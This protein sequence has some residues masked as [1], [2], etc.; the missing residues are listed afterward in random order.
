[1]MLHPLI[2]VIKS[3]DNVAK[4]TQWQRGDVFRVEG[5]SSEGEM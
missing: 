3:Y 4:V 2:S 1:M 5:N